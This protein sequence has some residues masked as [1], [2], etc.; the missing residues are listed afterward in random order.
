MKT[1]QNLIGGVWQD[2]RGTRF[3]DVVNPAT[4]EAVARCPSGS[5]EDAR[6]AVDAAVAA[7]PAWAALPV[8]D[9]VARL[10]RWADTVAAH[11]GE[12]A[13]AEC[14]EM[15]KP[16]ALGAAFI[17][18]A[19][20]AFKV[21]V[22]EALDYPFEETIAGQDGGS[23]T[24]VRHPLGATA[25]IVPWNFPVPMTLGALGPLLA[26]G[27]TVVLKPSERS[28]LS[29]V[30]LLELMDLPAGVV[31]L[32]LGDSRAGAPLT[33]DERIGLVHFTGSVE[34]GREVGARS[35]GL[36]HRSILELGGKDPVIVDAGV[37]PVATAAAVAFGAF[38]NTGQICT[39][40]ERVYVHRD[41]AEP[42]IA[43]LVEAAGA[44]PA[45]D[46]LGPLVDRRQRDVV[47][48][49]V[50]DA[51]ER[52][53]TVRA[54]GVVPEGKGFYYPATV[55]T[56]VDE[57]MLIM[58]EETFG[59]VA[60]VAVVSSFEEGVERASATRYGLA[61]T[62]YTADPAHVAAARRIPA[63]VVWVNQ[64][65]GGGPERLYEPA[66]DSGMGA[67]GA[68]AA[69]DAATRPTSVHLAPT[70]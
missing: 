48:R 19:A 23:T 3:H 2:A 45:G 67:T 16:V 22:A 60:P 4:E 31:N 34:A 61:A 44:Y 27:N 56:D 14:L 46:V 26:A 5:A 70:A 54:G 53:A 1:L 42:F 28:P 30:R 55:L 33:A 59:P 25:V 10:T 35:G 63:G 65:Q 11:A 20:Q 64:W 17:G 58:T 32:V 36:L 9:R 66:G 62:V 8:A 29:A 21:A 49:H 12:L 7:Q 15:G 6:L 37:D 50:T 40:M 47:V 13:E 52:G 41:V 69:Y 68:R 24:I 57:S 51:V 18:G 38:A 39:S 43:A